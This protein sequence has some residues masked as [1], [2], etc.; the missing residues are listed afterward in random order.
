MRNWSS[1]YLSVEALAGSSLDA[2]IREAVQLSKTIGVGVDFQFN[3]VKVLTGPDTDEKELFEV[4]MAAMSKPKP[5][6]AAAWKQQ[7]IPM[8]FSVTTEH[9]D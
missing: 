4:V 9:K 2:C 8:R 5:R 1:L 3:S 6:I 7:G